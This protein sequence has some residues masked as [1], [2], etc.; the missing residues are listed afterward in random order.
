MECEIIE[1]KPSE[2]SQRV[3]IEV[4]YT[5][6]NGQKKRKGWGFD[7]LAFE[8]GGYLNVIKSEIEKEM[9]IPEVP[10]HIKDKIKD[11]KGKIIDLNNKTI[12]E[13]VK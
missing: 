13:N 5:L 8:D 1:C 12:K 9:S 6:S 3:Y 2:D 11:Y 10:Q 4:E 7:H